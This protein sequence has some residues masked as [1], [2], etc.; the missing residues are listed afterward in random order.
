MGS[1]GKRRVHGDNKP[2]CFGRQRN[3]KGCY[4]KYQNIKIL[5]RSRRI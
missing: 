5:S 4:K 2:I 3:L 1:S